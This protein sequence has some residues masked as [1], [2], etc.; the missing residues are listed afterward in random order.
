MYSCKLNIQIFSLFLR[1]L[2]LQVTKK[3]T[4]LYIFT[5]VCI[6]FC[7]IVC[8]LCEQ[9]ICISDYKYT[10]LLQ[11]VGTYLC[12]DKLKWKF[13][14]FQLLY[15][16]I[17]FQNE[18]LKK[19]NLL[20]F[21]PNNQFSLTISKACLLFSANLSK[22]FGTTICLLCIFHQLFIHTTSQPIPLGSFSQSVI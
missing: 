19:V 3:D 22:S 4:Y 6:F 17:F 13:K 10:F 8:F 11:S 12:K 2:K 7:I 16:T 20:I 15:I 9:L 14:Q 1:R 5:F 21:Q 18:L